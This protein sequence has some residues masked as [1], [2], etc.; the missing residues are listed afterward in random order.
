MKTPKKTMTDKKILVVAGRLLYGDNWIGRAALLLG[1]HR[2]TVTRWLN[3]VH[4]IPYGVP[5]ILVQELRKKRDELD[6]WTNYLGIQV[7][8]EKSYIRPVIDYIAEYQ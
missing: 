8:G 6:A 3:G 4:S 5:S 2:T 1:V 7:Y